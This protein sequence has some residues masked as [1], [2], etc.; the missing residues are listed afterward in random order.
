MCLG[1]FN[2]IPQLIR[3]MRIPHAN[4]LN[5]QTTVT[6]WTDH[7]HKALHCRR[8][9]YQ[10]SYQGSPY[11]GAKHWKTKIFSA[12]FNLFYNQYEIRVWKFLSLI[13]LTLNKQ[14]HSNLHLILNVNKTF[15][16]YL[17][18]F[19]FLFLLFFRKPKNKHRSKCQIFD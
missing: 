1:V 16:T 12:P 4:F 8:I 2:V 18:W 5:P 9:L 3:I 19:L 14:E 7:I 13:Q 6:R 17:C 11:N 10:L 15:S